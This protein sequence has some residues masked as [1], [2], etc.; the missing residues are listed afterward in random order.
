MFIHYAPFTIRFITFL[1][2]PVVYVAPPFFHAIEEHELTTENRITP[3]YHLVEAIKHHPETHEEYHYLR[4][5]ST[6]ISF[7][8][9]TVAA[10]Y[11]TSP[12]STSS[13]GVGSD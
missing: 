7:S 5:D 9:V 10:Y 2:P 13:S 12:Y 1:V 3:P 11:S 6:S 8:S 4:V